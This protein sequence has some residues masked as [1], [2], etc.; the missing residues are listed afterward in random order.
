MVNN[1]RSELDI[2]IGILSSSK[3]GTNKTS[4]LY[5]NN[6]S[7]TQLQVYLP[8]LIEKKVIEEVCAKYEDR[9]MKLYR[10]TP[11]GLCLIEDAKRVLEILR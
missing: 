7:Y 3:D 5:K 1:R 8:F 10:T 6:L 11:K 2:V 9:D 4:I